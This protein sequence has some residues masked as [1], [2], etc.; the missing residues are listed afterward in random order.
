MRQKQVWSFIKALDYTS[1]DHA[2][3]AGFEFAKQEL[4]KSLRHDTDAFRIVS[5]LGENETELVEHFDE[6]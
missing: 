4:K 1:L 5:E 2:W 6:T 3:L